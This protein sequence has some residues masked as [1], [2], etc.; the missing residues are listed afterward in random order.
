MHFYR[1]DWVSSFQ[2]LLKGSEDEQAR[3]CFMVGQ[4]LYFT[5]LLCE[6]QV[7]DL[8]G[9]GFLTKEE[10]LVWLKDSLGDFG[11]GAEGDDDIRVMKI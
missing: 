5:V 7:Y 11:K 1:K 10:L 9:N 8:N 4:F 2:I 3:Y 6:M